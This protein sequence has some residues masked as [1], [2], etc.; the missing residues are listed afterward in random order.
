MNMYLLDIDEN[1]NLHDAGLDYK[2]TIHVSLNKISKYILNMY[3]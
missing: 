1:G 3:A 2:L